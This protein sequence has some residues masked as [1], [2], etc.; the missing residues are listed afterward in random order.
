SEGQLELLEASSRAAE[1]FSS[2]IAHLGA[3][4]DQ[5]VQAT[6]NLERAAG[7]TSSLAE[8]LE[9]RVREIH[10]QLEHYRTANSELREAIAGQL[11]AVVEQT[12]H[13]TEF[14]QQFRGDLQ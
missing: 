9:T 11:D 2:S 3:A 7:H 5:V 13:L 10:S 1:Q 4:N 12:S 6:A 8:A 14:W